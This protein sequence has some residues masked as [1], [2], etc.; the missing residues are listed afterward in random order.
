MNRC[1]LLSCTQTK[2]EDE[3]L[4]PTID[5]YDGPSFRVVRRFLSDDQ[6]K[7]GS[8][9]IYVLSAQYGLIDADTPI[10]NYERRMTTAR[11]KE[12]RDDVLAELKAILNRDYDELFILL[13]RSYRQAIEGLDDLIPSGTKVIISRSTAGRR[14]TEL[15]RWLYRLPEEAPPVQEPKKPARVTGQAVLR[16]QHIEATPEQVM[17]LARQALERGWGK[18]DRFR[19]WYALVDGRK[20]STKWLASLLSGLEVSEFQASEARRVLAQIG[21]P[22]YHDE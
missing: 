12:L 13:G 10:A 15:K 3:G 11:A 20:V 21:I 18:P 7:A 1:L 6:S 16:G 9:D 14:L 4:L 5:R 2:R 22:M 17:K 8:L 19:R